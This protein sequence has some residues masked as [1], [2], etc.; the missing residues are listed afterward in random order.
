MIKTISP[1]EV[2]RR[3]SFDKD[4]TLV[5]VRTPPEYVEG[6]IPGSILLPL[7]MLET[8]AEEKMPNKNAII[9]VYCELGRKSAAAAF[10]LH[11]LGYRNIYNMGGI[12]G[13]PYETET[14]M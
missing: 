8:F 2:K 6:H 4:I 11:N 3:L 7:E 13:W 12:I 10:M 5:D 14:G 9:V 1:S